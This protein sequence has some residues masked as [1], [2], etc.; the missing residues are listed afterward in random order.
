MRRSNL[1]YALLGILFLLVMILDSK[2][3]LSGAAQGIDLCMV[4]VIPSLFP[5]FVVSSFLTDA[6]TGC[7]I[8]FP[9]LLRKWAGI[10]EG[11]QSLF[12]IGLCGGY[13]VGAQCI[14]RAAKSGT[15]TAPDG[16]R[17]ICFCNNA[18][19]A[20][21]FGIGA[22]LFPEMWLCWLLWG[23]HIISALV[24]AFLTP[25]SPMHTCRTFSVSSIS[26]PNA[27]RSAVQ[28]IALVCGWVIVMRTIIAFCAH[29][30]LWLLPSN[31]QLLLVGLLEM[32]NGC[33]NLKA[34]SSVGQKMQIFSV[35]LG[36]GGLCV[37]LQTRSALASS[38]LRGKFYF[39]G[40][41]TQAAISY[42]LCVF[43]QPL[44]PKQMR[45]YPPVQ[46]PLLALLICVGY[47]FYW[48]KIKNGSSFSAAVGV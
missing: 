34:L 9:N 31:C 1:L 23:I 2:T 13:P 16:E 27:L 39:P 44:L 24:V 19:P 33:V 14:A 29:W 37:L 45:F 25:K 30:F 4:T 22:S 41:V 48:M 46:L 8:P 35:F 17:M 38:Q 28:S 26:F 42:L 47:G 12:L 32:T 7:K 15:L 6:L 36:F 5:F 18:G 21:L 40:K 11:A 43:L 10:P 3:A 20:F